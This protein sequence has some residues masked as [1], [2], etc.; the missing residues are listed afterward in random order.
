VH[1]GPPCLNIS[2]GHVTRHQYRLTGAGRSDQIV[3]LDDETD[4][5]RPLFLIYSLVKDNA[6]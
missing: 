6:L 2:K 5:T 3:G 1:L 4:V